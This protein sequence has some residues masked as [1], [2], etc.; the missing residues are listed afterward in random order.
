MQKYWILVLVK[1]GC[2]TEPEIF[3]SEKAAETRKTQLLRDFNRDYDEIAVFEKDF[4]P[5]PSF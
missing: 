5:Q 2:I 4:Q 3:Y 1:R